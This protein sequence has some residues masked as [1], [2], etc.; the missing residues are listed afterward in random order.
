MPSNLAPRWSCLQFLAA[1]PIT[2]TATFVGAV[3][4][5]CAAGVM[6][7]GIAVTLIAVSLAFLVQN[8]FTRRLVSREMAAAARRKRAAQR[9][10]KLERSGSPRRGDLAE[11]TDL[12]DEIASGSPGESTEL[13][14]EEL[15]DLFVDRAAAQERFRNAVRRAATLPPADVP[16]AAPASPP[17]A[18]H[19]D[20]I[21]R[22]AEHRDDCRR[23]IEEL[24]LELDAIAELV[25]LVAQKVSCPAGDLPSIEQAIERRLWELDARSEA[26]A[27]LE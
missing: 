19:A 10:V 9:N 6:A 21:R 1:Q 7:A 15:L 18:A 8:R 25:R 4:L 26:M 20:L 12:V 17:R 24:E 27:Q 22:R 5:G 23:R 14:L 2:L 3:V 13:D 16:L 11:L